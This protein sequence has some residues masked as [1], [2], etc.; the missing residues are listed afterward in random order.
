MVCALSKFPAVAPLANMLPT[1][2][3]KKVTSEW[4]C[5]YGRMGKLVMDQGPG[6]VGSAW[7]L[8]ADCW[9]C[10]LVS[11]SKNAEFSNGIAEKHIDLVK[12]GMEK[13]RRMYPSLSENEAV[14]KVVLAKNMVP[15]LGS[16]LAPMAALFG[17]N[18][19]ISPLQT[20]PQ[21]EANCIPGEEVVGGN[22]VQNHLTRLF[23]LR[24]YLGKQEA[25]RTLRISATQRLRAGATQNFQAGQ[26][27]D[28]YDQG[29]KK[30]VG[31]V[32]RDWEKQF[33]SISRERKT[34][35]QTSCS[36]G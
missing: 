25:K 5:R 14:G 23:E 19:L 26:L 29:L 21:N 28:I 10:Q 12:C 9:G 33:T 11:T 35:R 32:C 36:V 18:N 13:A 34:H 6:M 16:G 24:E 15:C 3:M 22:Q 20:F 2:L 17:R 30:M 8:F 4:I 7:D 1:T 31:R 27:I